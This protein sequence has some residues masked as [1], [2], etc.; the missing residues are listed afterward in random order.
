MVTNKGII[1]QMA[2]CEQCGIL[3]EDYLNSKARKVAYKHAKE[4]NHKVTVETGSFITY[5]SNN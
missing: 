1:H 2:I 3:S 5:N 4:W